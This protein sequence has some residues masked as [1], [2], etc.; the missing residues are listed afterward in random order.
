MPFTMKVLHTVKQ[1]SVTDYTTTSTGS[2]GSITKDS[3]KTATFINTYAT[4]TGNLVVS[5]VNSSG[6]SSDA[7]TYTVTLGSTSISG[8]YGGMTFIN[9]VASFSLTGGNSKTASGLPAG[10]TYTVT[11]ASK[12]NYTVTSSGTTG[13]ITKGAS[14]TASFTNTYSAPSP[15]TGTLVISVVN[16][17]GSAEQAFDYTITLGDA[18][19]SGLYGDV[20]FN[21]GVG[22]VSILSGG[23][24]TIPGLPVTSYMVSQ[25]ENASYTTTSENAAGTI[26][27]GSSATATFTNTIIQDSEKPSRVVDHPIL[28]VKT[29]IPVANY[30]IG[31]VRP[32]YPTTGL[33][34]ALVEK[35]Y[36]TSIQIYTGYAWEAVDARIWTGSRWIPYNFFN[37]ITLN[38]SCRGC[39]HRLLFDIRLSGL[40]RLPLPEN[41]FRAGSYAPKKQRTQDPARSSSFFPFSQHREA[42]QTV[43]FQQSSV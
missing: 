42:V 43:L 25:N 28:A 36:I 37:V 15:S 18:S 4:P 16:D 6:A 41:I 2:T 22:N 30:Q 38:D 32:A 13:T 24:V 19:V 34:W 40:L 35:G 39:S 10:T 3:T 20:N 17:G 21:S 8:T 1:A 11:Q 5:C 31:G 9:G 33:V 29:Q 7:F 26:V 12:A 27:A 23:S 14:K